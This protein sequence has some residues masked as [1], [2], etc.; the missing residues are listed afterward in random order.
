M[1]RTNT[2]ASCAKYDIAAYIYCNLHN[3]WAVWSAVPRELFPADQLVES[4]S[5]RFFYK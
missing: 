1:P 3:V 5:D 4:I 2:H